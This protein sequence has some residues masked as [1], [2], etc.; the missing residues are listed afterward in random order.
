M[1]TF[2]YIT[3]GKHSD[4]KALD[5]FIIAPGAFNVMDRGELDVARLYRLHCTGASFLIRA[6]WS[7]NL[8]IST[9]TRELPSARPP[10][11]AAGGPCR[12]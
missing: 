11:I 4:V 5:L 3:S 9:P 1:P 7:R 10:P 2:R 6:K 12:D 8:S